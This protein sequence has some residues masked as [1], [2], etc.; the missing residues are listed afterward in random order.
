MTWTSD[1]ALRDIANGIFSLY[2]IPEVELSIARLDDQVN[3]TP[4]RTAQ[5]FLDLFKGCW[6]NPEEVV[7]D[8]L[9]DGKRYD[10]LIYVN[11]ISFVSVCA[12]HSLP[13]L[14]KCHFAYQPNEKIIGIS[15]I[16]RLVDCYA[17]RPQ[18]QEK[19]AQDIVDAFEYIVHPRG[20]G[21]I[22]EALHLCMMVRGVE[23][24]PAYTKTSALRGTFLSEISTKQEFLDGVRKTTE[25]IWP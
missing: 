21:V 6:Q 18:I 8:A 22:I 12:H 1:G 3:K 23:Q 20:C 17:R 10:Q 4:R 19:L 24:R 15:K 13:F 9:F 25:Q 7:G 5:A 14:G 16:P 11:D 2:H